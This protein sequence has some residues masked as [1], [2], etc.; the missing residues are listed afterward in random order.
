ML[1]NKFGCDFAVEFRGYKTSDAGNYQ[2]ELRRLKEVNESVD[3]IFTGFSTVNVANTYDAAVEDGLL[4]ALN[5]MLNTDDG[6]KLWEAYPEKIWSRMSRNGEYYAVLN[7]ENM[8]T[9]PL[10]IINSKYVKDVSVI[11]NIK[12]IEDVYLFIDS[13]GEIEDGVVPLL[14]DIDSWYEFSGGYTFGPCILGKEN[15]GK[16]EAFFSLEDEEYLSRL[17]KL[18][19][20][21]I[22]KG[23]THANAKKLGKFVVMISDM[24]I[25]EYSG[26]SILVKEKLD[27]SE[28]YELEVYECASGAGWY[29]Y[30]SNMV[31]GIASWSQYKGESLKLLALI[32]SE[33]ELSNLLMYGLEGVHYKLVDDKVV[34]LDYN[35]ENGR[36]PAESSSLGNYMITYPSGLE[37]FDKISHFNEYSDKMNL[38]VSSQ[39]NVDLS[40]YN[41]LQYKINS[42]YSDYTNWLYKDNYMELLEE[43]RSKMKAEGIYELIN[44]INRQLDE[45]QK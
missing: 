10:I 13:L 11:D 5:G 34:Y 43:M 16:W 22:V 2:K 44:E 42:I 24:W 18:R 26:S 3:I 30:M 35:K 40:T 25:S 31:I 36:V 12:T 8:K 14:A 6:K 15:D 37:K 39:Y 27:S 1:V 19:N 23:I 41:A 28:Y 17:T 4:E 7:Q 32:A 9:S 33:P 21:G 45:A 20:Y 29:E 38:G